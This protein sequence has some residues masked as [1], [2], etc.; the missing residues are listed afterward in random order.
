MG[1]KQ[2]LS[3][4]SMAIIGASDKEGF[5][6]DT[7]RN[8]LAYA[9]DSNVYFVNPKRERLFDRPCYKS[10]SDLPED[11]D[12]VIICTPQKTVVP[13][14]REAAAKG[15]GGAVVYASGYSEVG[16]EEG[17]RAEEE[18]RSVCAELDI[19]LM[20]P[21]C[22]GFMN[23]NDGISA[24]AFISEERDR[25]GGV[26]IVSQS[27]QLCL[28]LMDSPNMRFSYS[29][30]SGNSSVVTM[31]DYLE[32]LIDDEQTKVV[33]LYLEGVTAPAK[34]LD[35][36]KRAAEMRK[37]VVVL[38]TGRS[39]KGSLVAASH[40]GSLAGADRV[41][42][43]IFE[44]FGVIRVD[45]LEE[46][47]ATTV[48][49][50]TLPE[51]P[52]GTGF[53]AISLSG[54]E[55]GMCADLGE[56][57]GIDYPDFTDA[58]LAKLNQLLPA[59][60]SPANPLDSTASI[61]YDADVYAGTLQAVMDDPGVDMVILGYTLLLEIADPAIHYMAEGIQKVVAGGNVKPVAML[62]FVENSRNPEYLSKLA[63]LGV[64]VL[65]PP[66]YA[67][68]VLGHLKRFI[69]YDPAA[70]R[71]EA[72]VPRKTMG[73][74]RRTLS[75][76][77]SMELL[78]GYGVPLPEGAIAT[79]AD[80][81]AEVAGKLGFPVVCKIASADIGHKSDM[82]GVMLHLADADSVRRA[83]EQIME[84]ARANAPAAKVDGVFVQRMLAPGLEVIVGVSNDPQFGP[85]IL[86]GLGGVF[87]EVFK[88]TAML[89]APVSEREALGMLNSL[90]SQPLLAGCRGQQPRDIDALAKTIARISEFAAE[91]RDSLA[92]LDC[93]PVFVYEQG[94]GV[95][96][97]DALVVL[98]E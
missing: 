16:T 50:S 7:C 94:R 6:G 33:G 71:L 69:E 27:G 83:F 97:A 98:A 87:V 26:G 38:K 72:A 31:E 79:S 96:A 93:N 56:M 74:K 49:F 1:M 57:Y 89:P 51:L 68:K 52:R 62:P 44:K 73:A 78:S 30:S 42:D 54:G 29:I 88:D 92:E 12:M 20:G 32:Y 58:T 61:S 60:A 48:L 10:V 55:T 85:C 47:L 19:A 59:Y 40:T 41:Y 65:P 35:C 64:P 36:L 9:P 90:R 63:E 15:A 37:P 4:K 81:A 95:F 24:F 84:N 21:N 17:R 11:V 22:A 75:E 46:L 28:S 80:Q 39:E 18:L 23:Y 86:C 70:H 77:E 53:S 13:L 66:A 2:L 76:F 34:F 82:G 43:A 25:K 91:H 14:L 8:V 3:P 67:F 45:D 5:G